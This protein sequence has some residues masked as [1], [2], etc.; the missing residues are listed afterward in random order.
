MNFFAI[1]KFLFSMLP[2]IIDGVKAAE[3]AFPNAGQ[4]SSKLGTVLSVIEAAHAAAPEL[5]AQYAQIKPIA[6]DM[7]N[8]VV[9]VLNKTGV[10]PVRPGGA[11][12]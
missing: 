9:Q 7:V 3:A 10:F 11:H 1:A 4:G 8:G 12:P 5:Q 2:M 6:T